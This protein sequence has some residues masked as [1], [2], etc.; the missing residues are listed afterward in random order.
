M[1]AP[2]FALDSR[3]NFAILRL[4]RRSRETRGAM[5]EPGESSD[6]F[7]V[8]DHRGSL[9]P[10]AEV[11]L[12][13][14]E[15]RRQKVRRVV[16]A[17]SATLLAAAT[18]YTVYYFVH[19]SAVESSAL[20]AGDR[21][22]EADVREALDTLGGSE[23]PG[24]RARLEAMSAL[25]GDATL[26]AASAALDV[27]PEGDE[28]QASERL[29]AETY[30]H[31]A[32]G[33]VAAAVAASSRLIARGTF[34]AE[35]AHARS[36]A[37]LANADASSALAE[38]Q[39]ATSVRTDAPRYVAQL[40]IASACAGDVEGA[41]G[42]LE[43]ASG[44][45][46]D[47]ARARVS[48]IARREGASEAADAV[49]GASDATP[50]ERAWAELVRAEVAARTGRR[51]EARER[52]ASALQTPP[53]GDATFL[54]A[55]AQVRLE[56][57]DAAGARELVA[58][59]SAP[60]AEVGLAGRVRAWLALEAN[61]PN[62]A[63]TELTAVPASPAAF[64]LVAR[65]H[66]QRSEWDEARTL[67]DRAAEHAG[68]AAEAL[69]ARAALELARERPEDAA[70]YARRALAA[71]TTHPARVAVAAR[72]LLA[73]NAATEALGVVDAA[74]AVHE[75]DD[76]PRQTPRTGD[77]R[78]LEAKGD[79][80]M[81][82]E[83]WADALA[84]LRTAAEARA[85]DASL[86]ARR[87]EAA[88]RAGELD[89]ARTAL[90]A[91]LELEAT[92]AR[93]LAQRFVLAVQASELD[94]AST[95][96]RRLND[97]RVDFT[98]ELLLAETRFHVGYGSGISGT[99][100][101]MRATRDRALRN[102]PELRIAIAELYL[103]AEMWRPAL[104]MFEQARRLG[105][106]RVEVAIGK[107]LASVMD[108]RGNV[109]AQALQ[110]ALDASLPEGAA[111]GT[112]PPAASHPRLLLARGRLELN[113]G[114]LPSARRYAE[115]ALAAREGY[116]EAHLLLAEIES[117]SRIDPT[118]SLRAALAAPAQP[119]AFALLA[120]RLGPTPEGCSLAQRYLDAVGRNGARVDSMESIRE[121]CAAE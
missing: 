91:A 103:Q 36:L 33:D 17:V 31:L 52:L 9:A 48:S 111:E 85:T 30:L 100:D 94:L 80:L 34:A 60:S 26:E 116:S 58:G 49:L 44:P 101:V 102:E 112:E 11:L 69:T 72:A 66:E 4:G 63:L 106:D 121:R 96:R 119:I 37:A 41:F 114:R 46:I 98:P 64:V 107:A 16:I 88:R 29:K 70:T 76:R 54:W 12:P 14:E 56:L 79:A 53:R 65:A 86:Q 55:S 113:L 25:A 47:L 28:E 42:A 117:R 75:A 45:A 92:N 115:R 13:P 81:A 84:A 97:A 19:A 35:T 78:L 5:K 110:D 59:L 6:L 109:A 77:D 21:G 8:E 71:D 67:Y 51:E 43:R 93:A 62:A 87:G 22:R 74:L 7:K 1:A 95:L 82:L 118:S 57:G 15:I 38:A 99:R 68:W 24:L 89:E 120:E 10:V 104:G 27:V 18:A 50:A 61:D 39:A 2:P 90:D 83:R 108:G 32:R 3:F 73:A 20:A 40:G 23:M 105:A